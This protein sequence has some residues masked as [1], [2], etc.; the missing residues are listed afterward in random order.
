MSD[1]DRTSSD[2]ENGSIKVLLIE[3]NLGDAVLIEQRLRSAR[4]IRY[5]FY[6]TERLKPGLERLA[7][8]DVDVVL[9]DLN[10]PDAHGMATV[11]AVHTEHPGLPIVVLTGLEDRKLGTSAIRHGAQDYLP[12]ARV[13]AELLSRTILHAIERQN[14]LTDLRESEAIRRS[15]AAKQLVLEQLHELTE[16]QRQFIDVVTHELRTPMTAIR[17]AASMLLDGTLG[18]LQPK[19]RQFLEMIERNTLRLARFATDVLSLSRLD[20]DRYPLHLTELLLSEVLAPPME[21]IRQSAA[22]KEIH[23]DLQHETIEGLKVH[24]DSDAV[25]QVVTN[26][27][28]NVVAHCPKGTTLTVTARPKGDRH[29][30]VSIADDGPGIPP[31]ALSKVFDRFYQSGRQSGPGYRGSGIG[32]T[33]CR[34]LVDR[35][36][37][38]I[39]VRSPLDE[40]TVFRFTL[41]TEATAAEPS[42]EGMLGTLAVHHGYV[43]DDQLQEGLRI[44]QTLRQSGVQ[45]AL[46][47]ILIEQGHLDLSDAI[48][49]L[50]MQG[51][52]IAACPRCGGRFNVERKP[53]GALCPRCGADLDVLRQP[54]RV[55]VDG[56][57]MDGE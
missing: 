1:Y 30:Q 39:S 20:A 27:A 7:D 38:N 40:G 23:V 16:I 56:A 11:D 54:D 41:P 42:D 52:D 34:A 26:L 35:M 25:A 14:L 18:E 6:R 51:L 5:T 29:V 24:A 44:Q 33:V 15:L 55:N 32:L 43:D 9:L 21:L 45:L 47:Q 50:E 28:N 4:D 10:L 22:D 3:D 8:G 12:K 13:S 37:G 19:Q 31:E 53:D 57:S 2:G 48:V 36:G 17:S 49:L 46:G